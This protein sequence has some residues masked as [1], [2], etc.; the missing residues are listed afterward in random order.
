MQVQNEIQ[1]RKRSH[2]IVDIAVEAYLRRDI[3]CGSP[4]CERCIP[5]VPSLPRGA[6]HY[7]IPDAEALWECLDILELPT[8]SGFIILTSV[9]RKVL[10]HG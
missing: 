6:R 1:L 7:V 5:K 2:S 3:S 10:L 8:F 4:A 9:L